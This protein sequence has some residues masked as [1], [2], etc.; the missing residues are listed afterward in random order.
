MAKFILQKSWQ[1]I[2]NI[3]HKHFPSRCAVILRIWIFLASSNCDLNRTI[4]SFRIVS[5][6]GIKKV[7][8]PLNLI[9]Q[10]VR[11]MRDRKGWTQEELSARLQVF[12]WDV[13]RESLAKLETQQRRVP[14]GELFVLGKVFGTGTD[15]LFPASV[16]IKKL[17]PDFRMRLSR[18]RVKNK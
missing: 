7:S 9:G 12:G 18:N 4:I 15:A 17:G 8:P 3:F 11:D 5:L 14:D 1:G 16:N 2:G 13:S 10:Q 6:A